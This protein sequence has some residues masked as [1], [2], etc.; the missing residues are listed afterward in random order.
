[1]LASLALICAAVYSILSGTSARRSPPTGLCLIGFTAVLACALVNATFYFDPTLEMNSPAKVALQTSLLFARLYYTAELRYLIDRA[2]PRLFIALS[3]LTLSVS[4]LSAI[5]I[6]VA[7][8]CGII[9]RKDCLAGAL[10]VLGIAIT[11]LLRLMRV[12]YTKENTTPTEAQTTFAP[13]YGSEED[14]Q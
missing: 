1:M 10:L 2:K 7:C 9:D 14:N 4:A 12:L 3:L 8:C 11:V 5:P 13:S 6:T